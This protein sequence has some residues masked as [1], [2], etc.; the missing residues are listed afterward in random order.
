MWLDTGTFASLMKASQFVQVIEE[1]QGLKVCSI[2][3]AAYTSGFI[4]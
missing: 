3:E 1:M 2:E 4:S